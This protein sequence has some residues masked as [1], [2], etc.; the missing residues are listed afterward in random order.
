M[1]S[2]CGSVGRPVNSDTRGP[3]FESNHLHNIQLM[4]CIGRGLQ[5]KTVS[6]KDHD[7]LRFD[8]FTITFILILFVVYFNMMVR[9]LDHFE[10]GLFC[11]VCST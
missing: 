8:L 2:G 11:P 4:Q 3:R 5:L 9:K 10:N 6:R 1:G 7:D